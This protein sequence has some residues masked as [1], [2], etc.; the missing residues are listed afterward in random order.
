MR[1]IVVVGA[2]IAGLCAGVYGLKCGYDVEIV[3]AHERP[4]GLATSWRRG[5]YTF[6]TCLDWLVGSRAG[7]PMYARWQ[8]VCDLSQLRF[9]H[10]EV[11]LRL[12]DDRGGRLSIFSDAART[13]DALLARAP[14]DAGEIREFMRDV[15]RFADF[16]MP[17]PDETPGETLARLARS[18]SYLPALRRWTSTTAAAYG[19][20]FTDPLLRSFFGAGEMGRISAL[21]VVFS[22]AWMHDRNADY[23]IGGSQALIGLIAGAFER[24]GDGCGSERRSNASAWSATPRPACGS[25]AARRSQPTG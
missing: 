25:S 3:E 21:A 11:Y 4:G 23:A 8:E 1:K 15:R 19:R 22:L 24:A 9:V 20:R 16:P 17:N 13:E 6:E 12:E 2:G 10:P 5:D 14:Q 7:S 18:V